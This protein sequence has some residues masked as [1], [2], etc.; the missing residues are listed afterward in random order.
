MVLSLKM[1]GQSRT[2]STLD[3]LFASLDRNNQAMGSI[4]ISKNG[5]VI[6]TN[7]I[8]QRFY[9]DK[10]R[11]DADVN[12]KYR[13]GSI[14]KMFTAVLIFQLIEEGQLTLNSSLKEYFP[15]LPNAEKITIRN[16]LSHTSGIPNIRTIKAR[17]KPHTQDQM[18]KIIAQKKDW[19]LPDTTSVYSNSNFLLLGY[20]I[21]KIT[22]KPY[23]EVLNERIVSRIG[24]S[25]SYFGQEIN[26]ENNE[27][28]SYRLKNKWRVQRQTH[29][30]IPGGSGGIVSTPTDLVKFVEAL[31][32]NKLIKPASLE[33]MKTISNQD[34]GMGLF[35][36]RLDNKT[37]F[38]HPGGIDRFES[39][40]AYF[41]GDS[42]A[43]AYCSNGQ[44]CPVRD[45]VI[46]CL[47]IYFGKQ[48]QIPDFKPVVMTSRKLKKYEGL[49]SSAQSPL[50]IRVYRNKNKLIARPGELSLSFELYPVSLDKFRCDQANVV[51]E[52][53]VP[54]NQMMVNMEGKIFN[55]RK[56]H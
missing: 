15:D 39:V 13:I 26:I 21:E 36:F 29:L 7:V 43:I 38:G 28:L 3:T 52:F 41:P 20:I 16:L 8:G 32:S 12:T 9:S 27:S 50:K 55:L 11:I 33:Q 37:A 48:Y 10:E 56:R 42:L 25:N 46:A 53:D 45:I 4:A 2:S 35:L 22:G 19:V 34:Y 5:S 17:R 51:V 47:N 1:F 6:Y 23:S 30:S 31:F 24:L 49:Y 44:V 14:S 40:V 54:N 18:L